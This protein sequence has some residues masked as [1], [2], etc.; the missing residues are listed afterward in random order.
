MNVPSTI[1]ITQA[2][3]I[4]AFVV[5]YWFLH[6]QYKRIGRRC[7]KKN[8]GRIDG[9]RIFKILL[10]PDEV[11]S[12]RSSENKFRW[13]IRRTIKLTFRVCKCGKIQLVKIDMNPISVWHAKWAKRWHPEQYH[14]TE[15]P[16]IM[17]SQATI[18]QLYLGGK[19]HNQNSRSNTT[20][21]PPL[22]A[23]TIFQCYW[24]M[25]SDALSAASEALTDKPDKPE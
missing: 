11:I 23:G 20:D 2:I 3:I 13:F 18:R 5:L 10:P 21:T 14:L 7:C 24:D 19:N 22:K 17:A 16:L 6:R 9:Q 4:I 12:W 15:Q 25:F 1:S 8:C